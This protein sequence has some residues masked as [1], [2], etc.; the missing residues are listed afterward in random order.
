MTCDASRMTH[1]ASRMSPDGQRPDAARD[2]GP[3]AAARRTAPTQTPLDRHPPCGYD[4]PATRLHLGGGRPAHWALIHTLLLQAGFPTM[5]STPQHP[6]HHRRGHANHAAHP[7]PGH[8]EH[9]ERVDHAGHPE[10]REHTD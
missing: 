5:S 7:E 3:P 2:D 10:H 1:H 6:E 4:G 9:T 8:T